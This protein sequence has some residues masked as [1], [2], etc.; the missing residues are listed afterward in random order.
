MKEIAKDEHGNRLFLTETNEVIL[1]LTQYG[2]DRKIG[3]LHKKPDGT[4][5]YYKEEKEKDTF[6]KNNSWSICWEIFKMVTGKINYRSEKG[7]YRIDITKAKEVGS[8][9]WFLKTG[10]EK[11]FYIPKEHWTFE[12][13]V[14]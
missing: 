14:Q 3:I 6:R 9:L 2:G 5:N 4:I 11:K 1:R 7:V 10:I 8:F 12:P 13:F